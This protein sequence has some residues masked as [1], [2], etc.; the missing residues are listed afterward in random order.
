MRPDTDG[1]LMKIKLL[2]TVALAFAISSPARA[3]D[4]SGTWLN[5]DKDGII[6]IGDCGILRK[7]PPVGALCGVVVWIRD[8]IDPATGKP[9]VDK[10]NADPALRNRPIMG[11]Q[12]L[13]QMRPSKTPNRWEGSVYNI[14]DGRTYAGSLT[15]GG[16]GHLRVEGC[17][18]IACSGETWT[19]QA[20]R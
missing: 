14:D 2:A 3:A 7:S 12:V 11:L 18:A 17:V 8:A 10:K 5:E 19:R 15:L 20:P 4:P 16:D 1:A 9:P 6:Q 13:T